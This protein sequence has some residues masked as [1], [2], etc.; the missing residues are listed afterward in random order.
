MKHEIFPD[1]ISKNTQVYKFMNILS[2]GDELFH[3]ER[4]TDMR[5]LIANFPNFARA[6]KNVYKISN[7]Y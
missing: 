7:S 5:N 4:R 2:L 1:R 6:S 3:A